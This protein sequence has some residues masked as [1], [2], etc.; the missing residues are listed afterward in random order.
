[1]TNRNIIIICVFV[2]TV[3]LVAGNFELPL[4]NG[5][6]KN[7]VVTAKIESCDLQKSTGGKTAGS[8]NFVGFYLSDKNAP[9]IRWNPDN[10]KFKV[11]SELCKKKVHVKIWYDATRL[12]LRPKVT[13]WLRE[14]GVIKT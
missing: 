10:D 13:Y 4:P 11:I 6:A 14:Y 1:M 2:G 7:S 12:I 9:Y 5:I 8:P 3:L